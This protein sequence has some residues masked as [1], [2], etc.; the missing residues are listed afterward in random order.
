MSRR[1]TRAARRAKKPAM[2][3]G[4]QC[5]NR[6]LRQIASPV[7][8]QRPI[9]LFPGASV[10]LPASRL[11]LAAGPLFS[12]PYGG[13]VRKVRKVLCCAV[14]ARGVAVRQV[15]VRLLL[16]GL[17]PTL[18]GF[19][20]GPVTV[21]TQI[22]VCIAGA[23]QRFGNSLF[24]DP[25]SRSH[26]AHAKGHGIERFVA[27]AVWGS[28]E[29]GYNTVERRGSVSLTARA[30]GCFRGPASTS[31]DPILIR[32]LVRADDIF[33]PLRQFRYCACPEGSS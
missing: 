8:E 18:D 33:Q 21:L 14:A 15:R 19:H 29:F 32:L 31:V 13:K 23:K 4:R 9:R 7:V 22:F 2:Y 5:L 20:R 16:A 11:L 30:V 12:G 26:P 24:V 28:A 17:D 27:L 10:R 3:R 6:K 25:P 1:H